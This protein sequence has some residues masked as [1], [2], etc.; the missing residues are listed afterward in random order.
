MNHTITELK[1]T[2]EVE[3]NFTKEIVIICY[4]VIV[5]NF[6][7]VPAN[8][9]RTCTVDVDLDQTFKTNLFKKLATSYC[10]EEKS[11]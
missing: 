5:L 11:H 7:R 8:P 6:E 9:H 1:L 10:Y 4:P 2:K 3:N